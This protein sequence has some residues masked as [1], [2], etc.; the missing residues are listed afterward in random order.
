MK[1]NQCQTH[2]GE[3]KEIEKKW[4]ALEKEKKAVKLN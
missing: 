4:I 1:K 2:S 3:D